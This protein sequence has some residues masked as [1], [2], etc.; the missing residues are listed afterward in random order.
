M[1]IEREIFFPKLAKKLVPNI[2]EAETKYMDDGF[3]E[4][5]VGVSF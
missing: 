4:R 2:S 3:A 5:R 1:V